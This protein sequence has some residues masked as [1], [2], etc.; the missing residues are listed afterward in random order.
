[1]AVSL[2]EL[3]TDSL[4]SVKLI[5]IT[6]RAE[7]MIAFQARV[8]NPKGQLSPI[9]NTAR[10]IR[11]LLEHKHWSPFEMASMCVEIKTTRDISAQILRHRSFSFQEFSQRYASTDRLGTAQ[12]PELRMQDPTNRQSSLYPEP[13]QAADLLRFSSEIAVLFDCSYDLYRRMLDYGVAKESARKILPMNS[14]T[15]LY[16]T[17]T[18]RSWIH[19]LQ[20][21]TAPETQKEHR[22]VA[23]EVSRLFQ[24]HLPTIYEV[25]QLCQRSTSPSAKPDESQPKPH[26]EAPTGS[27]LKGFFLRPVSFIRSQVVEFLT[28]RPAPRT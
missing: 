2:K 16:M 1:M 20:I 6:P 18:I 27:R 10:F 21:R 5:W 23:Q 15:R 7:E 11:Y 22:E 14:P 28:E 4:S 8:T 19:Y 26:R 17:G 25:A 3:H 13:S 24:T 9:N 12:L